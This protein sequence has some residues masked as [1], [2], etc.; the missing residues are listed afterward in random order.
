MIPAMIILMTAEVVGVLGV[1]LPYAFNENRT[2]FQILAATLA[3]LALLALGG[4]WWRRPWALWAALVV[5]SLQATIDL[6]AVARGIY[7]AQGKVSFLLLAAITGLTFVEGMP[8]TPNVRFGQR[9]LFGLVLSFAAWVAFWGWFRPVE[10]MSAI[11]L[12]VLPLHA[13]FLGAM[14]LAGAVLML[15]GMIARRWSEVRVITLMLALW[16]GAIGIISV[17]HVAA[18][19]WSLRTTWFWFVAYIAYPLIGLWIAWCQHG[20]AAAD[21]GCALSSLLRMYLSVQGMIAVA[22]ALALLLAPRFMTTVWPWPTST[23]L[24]QIYGAPFLSFG[25]GSLY[26]SR[27]DTWREVLIAALGTLVFC[28]GAL[29]ASVIHANL[30]NPHTLSA[31][32]WFGGF[33]ANSLALLLF[34]AIPSLRGRDVIRPTMP[35]AGPF[36]IQRKPPS[37]TRDA[38]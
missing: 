15:L 17:L 9:A 16:T 10:I 14:Y 38:P 7:A 6:C 30:F 20:E 18:F 11:P 22:L 28:I 27:Q 33:A 34:F 1:L 31:W 8:A 2:E 13:R 5:V 4:L 19:D 23:L 32:C 21:P 12:S 29:V 24:T 26:A 25:L 3:S 37:K 35:G 36:F